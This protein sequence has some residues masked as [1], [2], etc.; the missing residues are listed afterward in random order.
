MV[1]QLFFQE[2]LAKSI[3]ACQIKNDTVLVKSIDGRLSNIRFIEKPAAVRFKLAKKDTLFVKP[4][5]NFSVYFVLKDIQ[6]GQLVFDY[7][8]QFNSNTFRMKKKI[9]DS[10]EMTYSCEF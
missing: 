1:N 5:N 10:G 3:N 8:S 7:N 9:I 2:Q 6:S 4:G